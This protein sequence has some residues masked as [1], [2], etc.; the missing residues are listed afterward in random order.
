MAV[1]GAPVAH[2]ND[3]ERA[4]RAA[5]EIHAAMRATSEKAGQQI[6]AHIGIASGQ[7]VASG[8]G[9]DQHYTMTGEFGEPRLAPHGCGRSWRNA[10]V[11][12]GLPGDRRRLSKARIAAALAQGH[13]RAGQR[14]QAEGP[15]PRPRR[16]APDGW[17]AD[18]I[19][20]VRGAAVG[21]PTAARI[22]TGSAAARRGRYRQ[23]AARR[24][25]RAACRGARA[26]S[27][28][29]RWCWI[30]A[31]ARDRTRFAHWCAACCRSRRAAP[32][33]LRAAAAATAIAGTAS[34]SLAMRYSS[35]TCWTCHNPP[36]CG[37]CSMQW[38]M[39]IAM[40]AARKPLRQSCATSARQPVFL[41]VEDIHWATPHILDHVAEITRVASDHPVILLLTPG[42]RAI[43]SPA[44][45]ASQ[46]AQTAIQHHRPAAAAPR[47]R[48]GHGVG[49]VRDRPPVAL[50]LRRAGGRQSAVP[51]AVAA[52]R[53]ASAAEGMPDSVQS[54]VQARVDALQPPTGWP[55]KRPPCLASASC[56]KALRQLIGREDY[57]FDVLI[58]RFFIRRQAEGFLFAHALIQEGIYNSLLAAQRTELHLKAAR[59]FPGQRSDALCAAPRPRRRCGRGRRLSCAR[60]WRRP[61]RSVSMRHWRCIARGIEIRVTTR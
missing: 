18:G 13:C 8:V 38:T 26:S 41:I 59:D 49:P 1:F 16:N 28:T 50:H 19:A 2:D 7:V 22:G 58:E 39:N 60:Q 33:P 15:H 35:T 48:P 36:I 4:A 31:S 40:P 20:A 61:R 43:R 21:L 9:G 57:S 51:R 55:C 34:S 27:A 14:F 10:G 3:P 52:P 44:H 37:R 42:S 32:R 53:E 25:V 24:G 29:A 54:L 23:D 5:L 56:R 45:G 12:H 47:G 6:Q 30:S 46:V 11:A 17:A